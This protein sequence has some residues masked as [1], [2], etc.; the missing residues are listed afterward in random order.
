[1]ATTNNE[2]EETTKALK[3]V[4]LDNKDK[5][6]INENEE[7]EES[8]NNTSTDNE[9]SLSPVG[10]ID[11]TNFSVKHPLQNR[12]TLWYDN[13]S[14]KTNQQSWAD[15]LKK[16]VT[17][18]TVEDFWRIFNN[19]SPASK[20]LVGANYHLFKNDVEPKWEHA[21]NV[22]GGKWNVAVKGS[23][24]QLDKWWLW[25]VLACIGESFEDENEICG[26][27]VSIRRGANRLALWTKTATLEGAQKRIG[28][29]LRK[30]LELPENIAVSY[31]VHSDSLKRNSSY[32]NKP[33]YEA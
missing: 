33:K 14:G 3:N 6:E 19:I 29:Q 16:V 20:L 7:E 25:S 30:C 2:I 4:D 17:F 27:V 22:K 32:N 31:T 12:W 26:C 21:E 9:G 11:P 5:N 18:E 15:Q 10:F 28:T 1:M 13:P 8:T 23:N 24:E